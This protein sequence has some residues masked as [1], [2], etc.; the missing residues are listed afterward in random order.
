M[1]DPHPPRAIET[2]VDELVADQ[3][4]LT[5]YA[6]MIAGASAGMGEHMVM[7][8][9]DTIKT[10]MQALAHPGQQLHTSLG[11]AM[12]A[13]LHRE[14]IKGLYHGVT[15][16]ALGAGPS[17]ALYFA[18]Y[19]AAKQFY[20]GNAP[21]HQPLA[22]AAAGVTA[23]IVNDGCMTPWDVVKQRMQV[24]HSPYSGIFQ[25][26]RATYKQEGP[27]A[28]F[29]SFWTTLLMNV[30]YT[31]IHFA[32]YES[33]KT[34]FSREKDGK[35]GEET[36]AVQLGAG[37]IA[38]GLAAA[39]TTPFDVVKTRLQLEGVHSATRYDTIAVRPVMRRILKE[40]GMN[41]LFRGWQPRVL[42]HIP[43][44]AICWGIYESFKS[45][46]SVHE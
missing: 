20:G 25:C 9:V 1:G 34:Y 33:C 15:A 7:Y 11:R 28:F 35:E 24:S 17:H 22:T 45:W 5:F 18:S 40:E 41:A 16:V 2:A 30:P 37:G 13:V 36:L 46:L 32:T 3:D 4:G 12:K 21:G 29:K 27:R 42:F 44:A 6:H 10:R 23:T 43:S 39:A 26:I 8:P 19:E 31:A 38:G 14:G